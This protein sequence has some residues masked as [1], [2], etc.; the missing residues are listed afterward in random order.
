M[1]IPYV[2]TISL[3]LPTVD[4]LSSLTKS[5]TTQFGIPEPDNHGP[6][7]G[8]LAL[9]DTTRA[10]STFNEYKEQKFSNAQ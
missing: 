5:Q 9:L 7:I 3:P 4:E 6:G 10:Q 1:N 8:A 2:P